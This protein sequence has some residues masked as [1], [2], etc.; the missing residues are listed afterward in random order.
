MSVGLAR[1]LTHIFKFFFSLVPQ[2]QRLDGHNPTATL[3]VDQAVVAVCPKFNPN[4]WVL[5]MYLL[6]VGLARL[7]LNLSSVFC[8]RLNDNQLQRSCS[9]YGLPTQAICSNIKGAS[10]QSVVLL[11]E[12]F[13]ATLEQLYVSSVSLRVGPCALSQAVGFLR[14]SLTFSRG[15]PFTRTSSWTN[16]LGQSQLEYLPWSNWE[17]CDSSLLFI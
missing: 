1:L 8:R 7:F 6:S 9:C 17:S 11:L 16:W 2:Q 4:Y 10:L 3:N 12:P 13:A 5:V 14:L 15:L